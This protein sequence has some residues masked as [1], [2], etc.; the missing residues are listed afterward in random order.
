MGGFD[1]ICET[2]THGPITTS[3]VLTRCGGLES[4][5]DLFPSE[6][7]IEDKSKADSLLKLFAVSQMSWLVLSVVVRGIT[8]LP[9]TQ[10]GIATIAFSVLAIATCLAN[11]SKPK[12]VDVPVQLRI[13]GLPE[14][15]GTDKEGKKI[16]DSRYFLLLFRLSYQQHGYRGRI[17]DDTF[18]IDGPL[19]L[20][21]CV[22]GIS[23]LVFGGLHCIA[24]S[25]EFPS[26]AEVL[27]WR[28]ASIA[29][30]TV[31][32][33]ALSG[34]LF[35]V[36]PI[37]DR[38]RKFAKFLQ[39]H[40][41]TLDRYPSTWWTSF[42][43]QSPVRASFEDSLIAAETPEILRS[44]N[45]PPR[46]RRRWTKTVPQEQNNVQ[47]S[48]DEKA[49]RVA[50]WDRQ[51]WDSMSFA[52]GEVRENWETI[53][54]GKDYDFCEAYCLIRECWDRMQKHPQ[55]ATLW[56]K[57]EDFIKDRLRLDDEDVPEG[58]F[59]EYFLPRE[60]ATIIQDQSLQTFKRHCDRVSRVIAIAAGI[61]YTI[62][63]I[64]LLV[65]AFTSLRSVPED[66]CTT[67]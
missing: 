45:Q 60:S 8:R 57:Y 62:A 26:E 48:P 39:T 37:I 66:V 14:G 41:A 47:D 22:T 16:H 15:A 54:S 5:S 31:P 61:F 34:S 50:K 19:P 10:L 7:D 44:A 51:N 4:R 24:W 23:T 36:Q 55:D 35:L 67:S 43:H 58:S 40:L 59:V 18:R 1:E 30:A 33:I 65:I 9:V 63:R 12:D 6:H 2:D 3:A 52:L 11:L 53:K 42:D 27:I 13:K 32:G 49:Y 56:G 28:I 21:S 64:A 25:F 29:S 17:S 38:K 46:R 20:V